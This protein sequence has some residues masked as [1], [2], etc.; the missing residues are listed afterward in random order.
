MGANLGCCHKRT[1]RTKSEIME[2]D[3]QIEKLTESLKGGSIASSKLSRGNSSH[4]ASSR[5]SGRGQM[6]NIDQ[7]NLLSDINSSEYQAPQNAKLVQRSST[8]KLLDGD[9]ENQNK[10]IPIITVSSGSPSEDLDK[11]PKDSKH[12][13][14]ENFGDTRQ[15]SFAEGRPAQHSTDSK[16]EFR[17]ANNTIIESPAAEEVK[18]EMSSQQTFLQHRNNTQS[19]I[20]T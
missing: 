7:A 20:E 9:I 16:K 15:A 5:G 19:T 4:S 3:A 13:S 18:E 11:I 1:G 6:L 17:S 8:Y 12:S 14:S 2:G 10:R